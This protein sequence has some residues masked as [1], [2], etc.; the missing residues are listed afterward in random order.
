MILLQLLGAFVL[1][2]GLSS[3]PQGLQVGHGPHAA[4]CAVAMMDF[5]L[6]FILVLVGGSLIIGL[7]L[8]HGG[9]ECLDEP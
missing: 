9:I 8:V 4:H 2:I 1:I 3:L 7:D 5:N 6:F